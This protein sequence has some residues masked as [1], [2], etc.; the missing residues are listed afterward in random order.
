[1]KRRNQIAIQIAPNL[2]RG[3]KPGRDRDH[4][5]FKSLG[6]ARTVVQ[7]PLDVPERPG[8]HS[9]GQFMNTRINGLVLIVPRSNPEGGIRLESGRNIQFSVSRLIVL[10]AQ[11]AGPSSQLRINTKH[12]QPCFHLNKGYQRRIV[13]NIFMHAAPS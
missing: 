8:P 2:W 12:Q 10:P 6:C 4:N 1:M 5:I 13:P 11:I 3:P 9:F 7:L